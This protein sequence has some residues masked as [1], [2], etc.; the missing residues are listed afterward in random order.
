M[1][2]LRNFKL[3]IEYDGSEFQ[4]WQLQKQCRT[5]QGDLENALLAIFK[6]NTRLY[7]SG[8]TDSGVHAKGQVANFKTITRLTTT[9]LLKAINA[10]LKKD[11]VVLQLE[12]T[13]QTF[14]ARYSAKRKTY[15]YW[16]LNRTLRSSLIHGHSLHVPYPLNIRRMR[17]ASQFFIGKNDFRSLASKDPAGGHDQNEKNTTRTIY[18]LEIKKKHEHLLIEIEANGFL[19]KMVRNI[20]GLL[21]E[22]GKGRLPATA[23]K[24]FLEQKNREVLVKKTAPAHGLYL[25]KVV[26]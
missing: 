5:V 21:L 11:V 14:H 10:H 7:G 17:E 3:T 19:Y 24:T 1:E 9:E 20:V 25:S 16:L 15:Q 26:Y 4:G 2:K 23:A 22:I 18:R 6:K 8:R 13:S 12:E